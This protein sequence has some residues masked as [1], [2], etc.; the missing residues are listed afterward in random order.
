MVKVAVTGG[1]ACG[2]STVGACLASDGVPVC[3]A[4]DLVH[5]LMRRGTDVHARIAAEFGLQV[6][7]A[8][9][10]IDRRTLGDIVFSDAARREALN[11]IVHPVV[12]Q[13]WERWLLAHGGH[14]AAVVIVPLVFEI[15]EEAAWDAIICVA[16]AGDLQISRLVRKGMS[17]EHARK[18]MEAQ[19][20]V[21][22]K[23]V[24]SD[25]VILNCGTLDLLR[26]QTRRAW[27][28]IVEK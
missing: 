20:P 28:H 25:F 19:M 6:L 3:D 5:G 13:E 22:E 27:R 11:A 1:I 14:E 12:K 9:G 4:D 21:A 17:M 23:I 26:D 16:C 7:N 2:K 24:R 15:G 18:R 8:A 10:E